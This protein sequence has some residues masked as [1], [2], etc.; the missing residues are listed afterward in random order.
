VRGVDV[1]ASSL[2]KVP[3]AGHADSAA[4][5]DH[6]GRADSATRADSAG[7]ADTANLATT[8]SG[9]TEPEPVHYLNEPGEPVTA[10]VEVV[11]PVGFYRDHEGVVHLQ[12]RVASTTELG[13]LV[14]TLP[15]AFR[16]AQNEV[17]DGV[18]TKEAPRVWVYAEGAIEILGAAKGETISLAGITWRLAPP[19]FKA[20]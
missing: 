9:L 1:V 3:S 12:G 5:A 6:T 17:F 20:Q 16:P 11:T 19:G 15:A 2:G 10:Q 14:T 8:A 4:N 18:A 7:H 13:A